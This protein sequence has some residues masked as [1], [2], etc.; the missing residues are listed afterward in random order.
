MTGIISVF[1]VRWRRLRCA[2]WRQTNWDVKWTTMVKVRKHINTNEPQITRHHV[3]MYLWK[4]KA[5]AQVS[6]NYRR[7]LGTAHHRR[8]PITESYVSDQSW[9]IMVRSRLGVSLLVISRNSSMTSSNRW[10]R[11]ILLLNVEQTKMPFVTLLIS[12][13]RHRA[14]FLNK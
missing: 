5:L 1:S 4:S 13:I 7:Q 14:L 3:M 2:W 6:C 10:F 11:V 12:L 9:L 8:C